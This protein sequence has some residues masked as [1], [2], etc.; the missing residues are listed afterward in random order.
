MH[1][2]VL[3]FLS[4]VKKQY[5]EYFSNVDVL[6][7]GSYDINGNN[8]QFFSSCKYTGIDIVDGK[9]VDVV[10]RVHDFEPGK[11]Y[12]TVISTEMLEHDE[13]YWQSLEKMYD[14]TKPKGML[15]VTAA[16]EGRKEHGTTRT[17]PKDSPLTNGYYKN[18]SVEMLESGLDLTKFSWFTISY[19]HND[20]RFVGVKREE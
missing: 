1:N 7:C 11:Q 13:Y 14:L 18:V 5:P 15:I 4:N 2:A 3:S 20:M 19:K 17:L 9:N 16:G 10:T 12:D 6:D 8:R